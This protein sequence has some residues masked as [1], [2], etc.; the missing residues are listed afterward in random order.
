MVCAFYAERCG[1]LSTKSKQ[2]AV[3]GAGPIGGILTAHLCAQ[4]HTVHLVDTWKV[5]IEQIREHGLRITGKESLLAYPAYLYDSIEALGDYVPDFVFICTKGCDLEAV[6]GQLRA[7]LKKSNAI[8]LCFQN[9]IDTE[10]IVTHHIERCRVLRAVISYA[11][12]LTG[13]GEIR[14]SFFTA[15]NYLGWLDAKG[16]E[17]CKETA[18]LITTSGLATEATGEIGRYEWRKTIFNTCTM[19]IGAVTGLNIQEM[20]QFPPTAQLVELLLQESVAV[21]AAYGF[22]YGPGFIEMVRNFNQNAGPHKPSMLVDLENRRKTENAFLVRRIAEY[23][24]QKG[25]PA[26][27]HRSMANIIDALEMRGLERS[28]QD[29]QD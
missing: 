11:G 29:K 27:V 18:V 10:Q 13:P 5:H 25:V 15:P 3:I 20:V 26:P 17:V 21:A 8:F 4:G 16:E 14:E 7:S 24:E 22:D 19:A 28:C 6:L 1:L 9:G 2:I 12:V 23:A